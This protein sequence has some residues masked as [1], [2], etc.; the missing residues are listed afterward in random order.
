MKNANVTFA[1]KKVT[2]NELE[3]V[4]SNQPNAIG[5]FAHV[6]QLT[7]PKVL[8][9]DR[10]TKEPVDFTVQKLTTLKVLLN[11]DYVSGVVNQL[12]REDKEKSEYKAGKNTMPLDLCENNQ[13]FGYFQGKGVLQY[14]PFDKSFPEVKYLK[15]GKE[16]E[17]SELGD[18]LPASNKAQN[19]GTEKEIF[20]RKLYVSN[21]V[22]ITINKVEYE[23]V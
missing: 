15:N 16:V 9:K 10:I 5:T 1:S 21:I 6:T 23:L 12:E 22:K 2:L 4:L 17:K 13:F 14:R 8:K 20:W 11:T 18:I 3:A 7:A 19:Q